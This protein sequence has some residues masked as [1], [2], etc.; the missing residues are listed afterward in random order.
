ET[1]CAVSPVY[2]DCASL[3]LLWDY[4][5][6]A[7][8]VDEGFTKVRDMGSRWSGTVAMADRTLL[9]A[10]TTAYVSCSSLCGGDGDYLCRDSPV[11]CFLASAWCDQISSV[12]L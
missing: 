8:C 12:F 11:G 10:S 4:R 6:I 7:G 3:A 5:C 9:Y 1:S 2:P